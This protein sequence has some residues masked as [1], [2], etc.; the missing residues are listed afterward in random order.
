MKDAMQRVQKLE[1]GAKQ[2]CLVKICSF[3]NPEI[4]DTLPLVLL[5]GLD[6]SL[7]K[8]FGECFSRFLLYL[9]FVA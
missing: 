1:H 9:P 2:R 7:D 5:E 8:G 3:A 4:Q 6:E